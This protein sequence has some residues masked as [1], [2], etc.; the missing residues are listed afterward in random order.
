MPAQFLPALTASS[1]NN[2]A[3]TSAETIY[4]AFN[5]WR[6]KREQPSDPAIF[7]QSIQRAVD[8]SRPVQFV[9]YWGKGPRSRIAEPDRQCL[10]FIDRFASAIRNTYRH[11]AEMNIIYTDTHAHLNG[12]ASESIRAYEND[13]RFEAHKFAFTVTRLSDIVAA[14]LPHDIPGEAGEPSEELLNLLEASAAKWYGGPLHPSAAARRYYDQNMIERAAIEHT[15][16]GAI[17]VTFNNSAHR[18]LFPAHMPVFYMYSLRKGVAVKPWFLD[19]AGQPAIMPMP[20]TH[21]TA[22]VAAA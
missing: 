13:I 8:A 2:P 10:S 20:A 16:P 1:A 15:F 7:L 3:R 22:S 4:R 11:G 17:F 18:G 12:H 6:F 21:S 9:I 19:S 14:S 5:T